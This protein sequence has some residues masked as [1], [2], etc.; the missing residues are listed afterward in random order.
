M[1]T[2]FEL[3]EEQDRDMQTLMTIITLDRMEVIGYLNISF[4]LIVGV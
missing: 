4:V 2:Q 3:T 1:G